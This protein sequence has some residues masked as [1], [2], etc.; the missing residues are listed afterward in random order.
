MPNGWGSATARTQWQADSQTVDGT[1]ASPAT[2]ARVLVATDKAALRQTL[3]AALQRKGFDADAASPDLA[4]VT[5]RAGELRATVAILDAS[6]A[7]SE[8]AI[9]LR[10]RMPDVRILALA[11]AGD[12]DVERGSGSRHVEVVPAHLALDDLVDVLHRHRTVAEAAARRPRPRAVSP[13][14]EAS[15]IGQLTPRER[16]VLEALIGGSTN[17]RIAESLAISRHTVRT[18]L[19]NIFAKLG[20]HTRLE[21]VAVGLRAGIRP[22]THDTHMTA[23]GD[24]R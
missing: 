17:K 8:C 23:N 12:D 1:P 18:H 14:A 11:A 19:Q 22:A 13:R 4:E 3:V 20:V 16:E 9:G 6:D 21:A 7:A 5:T 15:P 10:E 24:G 2:S